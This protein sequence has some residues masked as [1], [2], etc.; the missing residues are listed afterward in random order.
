MLLVGQNTV[1]GRSVAVRGYV[2]GGGRMTLSGS[3]KELLGNPA[4]HD[5]YLGGG[6][7]SASGSASPRTLPGFM[8]LNGSTACLIRRISASA[9]GSS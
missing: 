7:A 1:L 3:R 6:P 2:L 9:T 4:V 8:R 5:A